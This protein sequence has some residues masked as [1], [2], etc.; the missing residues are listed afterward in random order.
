M[1]KATKS[2]IYDLILQCTLEFCSS[3]KLNS[4]SATLGE[5]LNI[6]RSLASQYLNEYFKD[7]TFIKISTRP[8]YFLDKKT[9][10]KSFRIDLKSN[11]FYDVN[12]LIQLVEKG[13]LAQKSFLQAIGHDT[14]LAYCI[15]QCQS[16]IK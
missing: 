16:A 11:E 1:D 10:E 9:V 13:L 3:Q 14:S 4:D 7:G 15:M 6:S 12:E 5:R 8:V 2:E